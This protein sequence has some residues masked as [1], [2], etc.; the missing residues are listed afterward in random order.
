MSRHAAG[1]G[2]RSAGPRFP[3]S[4]AAVGRRAMRS[5]ETSIWGVSLL[6]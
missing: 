5:K 6:W 4:R 3:L 2:F 1:R